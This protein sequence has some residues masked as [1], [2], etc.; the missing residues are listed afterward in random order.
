MSPATIL[1]NNVIL[2][3]V[4]VASVMV[5]LACA[6]A[7]ARA[8]ATSSS[9]AWVLGAS[10]E[11]DMARRRWLA[12]PTKGKVQWW[13][14]LLLIPVFGCRW[15]LE[16]RDDEALLLVLTKAATAPEQVAPLAHHRTYQ[17]KPQRVDDD[18]DAAV[19]FGT[20]HSRCCSIQNGGCCRRD[21]R[22]PAKV[23][24]RRT[25]RTSAMRRL[26]EWSESRD[27]D[28]ESR[29]IPGLQDSTT[30]TAAGSIA[31]RLK[32]PEKRILLTS[33]R[34]A[35]SESASELPALEPAVQFLSALAPW[36]P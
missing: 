26:R 20:P 22:S 21:R 14:L 16:R 19:F 4:V 7:A 31:A 6:A 23:T 32:H 30:Q 5:M 8:K 35:M 36:V 24:R 11:V 1:S 28:P 33:R 15:S 3:V 29:T 10:E 13:M 2:S 27:L 12:P 17:C 34:F 18:G 25:E 9:L